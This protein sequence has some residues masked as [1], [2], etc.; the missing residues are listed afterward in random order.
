[1]VS[2]TSEQRQTAQLQNECEPLSG[3]VLSTSLAIELRDP[4]ERSS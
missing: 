3:R 1:M 4:A 2:V